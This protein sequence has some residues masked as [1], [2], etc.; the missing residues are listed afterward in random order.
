MGIT[1]ILFG[2]FASYFKPPNSLEE[3]RKLGLAA[4][5]KRLHAQATGSHATTL[6]ALRLAD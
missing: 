3:E 6:C 5:W 1:W 2:F 4:S